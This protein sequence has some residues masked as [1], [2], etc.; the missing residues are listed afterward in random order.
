MTNVTGIGQF[1]AGW[2]PAHLQEIE[3]RHVE[4][5]EQGGNRILTA[6][7]KAAQSACASRLV[8]SVAAAAQGPFR[9]TA[10]ALSWAMG[11]CVTVP[12]SVLS[13]AVKEGFYESSLD[14]DVPRQTLYYE[15]EPALTEKRGTI[16][17]L[18]E[19]SLR[20]F[21]LG[22]D[23]THDAVRTL[24]VKENGETEFYYFSEYADSSFSTDVR[25]IEIDGRLVQVTRQF[26]VSK[27]ERMNRVEIIIDGQSRF[28]KKGAESLRPIEGTI[29][30]PQNGWQRKYYTLKTRLKS[31]KQ[32][33]AVIQVPKQAAHYEVADEVDLPTSKS[34]TFTINGEKR[35]FQ[36]VKAVER[37]TY[38]I[39]EIFNKIPYLPIKLP[40]HLRPTTIRIANFITKHL[41][42]IIRAVTIAAGIALLALGSYLTSI[43]IF[44]ALVYGYLDRD[45]GVIPRKV[46]LFME[47]WL[48]LISIVG[49]FFVGSLLDKILCSFA[50]ISYIPSIHRFVH[51]KIDSFYRK[52]LL[53]PV[54]KVGASIVPLLGG[55]KP[56]AKDQAE[57]EKLLSSLPRLEECNAP[58]EEQRK[59]SLKQ[60]RKILNAKPN[61][62]TFNAPHLVT[63]FLPPLSLKTNRNFKEFVTLWD[64][65]YGKNPEKHYRRFMRKLADDKRFLEHLNEKLE[66][67]NNKLKEQN[68]NL[69]PRIKRFFYTPSPEVQHLNKYNEEDR[70]K[71]TEDW[72]KQFL[73]HAQDF[74]AAVKAVAGK[75]GALKFIMKWTRQQLDIFV[76]KITAVEEG[77]SVPV[78]G[79]HIQIQEASEKAATI[80]AFLQNANSSQVEKKEFLL[81][82]AVGEEDSLL[83]LAVEAGDYCN[84]AILRTTKQVLER[85]TT[86]L[87]EEEAKKQNKTIDQSIRARL[88]TERLRIMQEMFHMIT[89]GLKSKEALQD[90][91]DDTHLYEAFAQLTRAGFYPQSDRE[92]AKFGINELILWNTAFMP[93]RVGLFKNYEKSIPRVMEDVARVYGQMEDDE[94]DSDL[95][96]EAAPAGQYSELNDK[97]YNFVMKRLRS[98]HLSL[99]TEDY[100]LL[101]EGIQCYGL[102]IPGAFASTMET[103]LDKVSS[104]LHEETLR[105]HYPSLNKLIQERKKQREI[106]ESMTLIK[107]ENA[108]LLNRDLDQAL[109]Q[110][111]NLL[112]ELF[113]PPEHNGIEW[114]QLL[115]ESQKTSSR[116][117]QKVWE[118]HPI[119]REMM[120]AINDDPK[121]LAEIKKKYPALG[122]LV[123]SLRRKHQNRILDNLRTWVEKNPALSKKER[124]QLL[125][126]EL[127]YSKENLRD[128]EFYKRIYRLQLVILGIYREKVEG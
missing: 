1:I 117:L 4:E 24:P 95:K 6:V 34:R 14:V 35:H 112:H 93:M 68:K 81:S 98:P 10:T 47:K 2:T 109:E 44:S 18:V 86:P 20:H 53:S 125:K 52:H 123:E 75:Q 74:E 64:Q 50:L 66:V 113:N 105:E 76:K 108:A 11:L 106:E 43:G 28:F 111:P 54:L 60:I 31:P 124:E 22:E 36:T 77:D 40:Q 65:I 15:I 32:G 56:T 13:A 59:L 97:L 101:E 89:Q 116:I 122:S 27:E 82:L 62:Y 78:Q 121:L 99:S 100:K 94:K 57:T 26:K 25:T 37:H 128:E 87:Y 119:L 90:T 45:L 48:P 67:L 8:S 83:A 73:K 39:A 104:D 107:R 21:M 49:F 127:A 46:S 110:N 5:V 120:E 92:K 84:L 91:G 30:G 114:I 72:H 79:E 71:I 85:Y 16:T 118:K 29:E 3:A 17:L 115:E 58:F 80:L 33:C 126:H 63:S 69:L 7:P 70:K 103:L 42:T 55:S 61:D 19:G 38:G 9:T 102:D 96:K 12:V 41:S 51:E 88:Q 23:V